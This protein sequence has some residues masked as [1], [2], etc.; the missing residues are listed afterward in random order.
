MKLTTAICYIV[1]NAETKRCSCRIKCAFYF[2]VSVVW[3]GAF[4]N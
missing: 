2:Q 3:L 1:V 4:S